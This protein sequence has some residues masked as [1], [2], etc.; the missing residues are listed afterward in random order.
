ME[1]YSCLDSPTTAI[2]SQALYYSLYITYIILRQY[3]TLQEFN[4]FPSFAYKSWYVNSSI[5]WL[6]LS[7]MLCERKWQLILYKFANDRLNPVTSV[8][9][10]TCSY[11][12]TRIIEDLYLSYTNSRRTVIAPYKVLD[13]AKLF[14]I[15]TV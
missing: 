9:P 8:V 7:Y 4:G 13:C 15:I 12:V 5:S 14:G 6:K 3:I 2:P 1:Y 10:F 11:I